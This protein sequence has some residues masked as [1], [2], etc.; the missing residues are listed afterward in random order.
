[1]LAV[2]IGTSHGAYKF[3]RKLDGN[4]LAIDR[5]RPIHD[6]VLNTPWVMHGSSIVP[7]ELQ[8][9]INAHGG[10]IAPT[11]SVSIDEIQ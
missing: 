7:K 10:D 5:L 6:R 1:V 2:A 3:T 9:I 11:W 8:D 4:I